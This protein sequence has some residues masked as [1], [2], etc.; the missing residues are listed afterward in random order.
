M[1][2]VQFLAIIASQAVALPLAPA[3]PKEELQY[4]LKNS[5]ARMILSTRG[6]EK[7]IDDLPNLS[8]PQR[9]LIAVIDRNLLDSADGDDVSF[10]R[11]DLG[12]G[13][14]MLYTSGTTNRPVRK[15]FFFCKTLP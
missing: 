8:P 10:Q 12:R 9:P 15:R 4:I 14:L 6:F 2:I 11:T 1:K 5:E 13:G 7:K 3:F